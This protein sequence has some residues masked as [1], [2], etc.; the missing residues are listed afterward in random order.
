[1]NIFQ[2]NGVDIFYFASV[3]AVFASV[4]AILRPL[5]QFSVRWCNFPFVGAILRPLVQLRINGFEQISSL[6]PSDSISPVMLKEIMEMFMTKILPGI[7]TAVAVPNAVATQNNGL[8]TAGNRNVITN[9]NNQK[10]N[11]NLFLNEEC[12]NAMNMNEFIQRV[13][14]T[15]EDL[16]HLGQVGYTDGMSKILTK[17]MRGI[18]TT[19]RP[20]HCTDTKRDTIYVKKDDAWKKDDDCEETKRL[21]QHIAHKN[22]KALKEWRDNHP[23]HSVSES[24]DYE[25]WYRISRNMCNTDPSALKKL[26]RHLAAVT[27]VEKAGL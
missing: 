13:N 26:I 21:I 22:Y 20:M 23:E 17:A 6:T 10:F 12:K 3:G 5:V 14:I 25:A 27:A 9:T 7:Q 4:G 16:E 2:K 24:E 1:L 19:D 18:E 15:S 8:L 11:L